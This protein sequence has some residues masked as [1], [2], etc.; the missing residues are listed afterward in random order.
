MAGHS[1]WANIRHRKGAQDKKKAKI[2]TKIA[3]E[4][5]ISARIGG[6][7]I[8]ANSRLRKAVSNAKSSNMGSDKIDRAIKKGTGDIE[9][10]IYEEIVYEGYSPGGAAIILNVITDN[11]NRSVADIRS[12]FNKHNGNLGESGS[13]SWMF[14]IKGQIIMASNSF[15]EN[16]IFEILIEL[17]AED[18]IEN[19]E[20]YI[21]RTSSNDFMRIRDSMESIGCAIKSAEVAMVPKSFQKLNEL[22]TDLT[23]RLLNSLDDNDD[24]NKIYTNFDYS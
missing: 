1:K 14:D 8:T 11:R 22:D 10:V 21:V 23:L 15:D 19:E 18:F 17:G 7:D 9:G 5:T 16:K 24:V 3:K 2:F 6:G 4:I 12:T 20:F 13:V